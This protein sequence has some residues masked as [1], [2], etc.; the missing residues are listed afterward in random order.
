MQDQVLSMEEIAAMGD[1]IAETA[2]LIDIA[3][4]RFLTQL[5][6]FDRVD[7]WHR[8]GALSCAHWLSWRVGMD[9]G[10]AREKVRVAKRLAELP[11]IDAALAR[12]E[13]SY[14]KVRAM[15]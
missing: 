7:G 9:L 15:T 10:A 3:T 12:G 14:A 1:R 11:V 6:E 13:I 4:H 2:A 5:R 8:A